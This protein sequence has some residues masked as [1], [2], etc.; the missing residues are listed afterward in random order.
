MFYLRPSVHEAQWLSFIC[1]VNKWFNG[2]EDLLFLLN[3]ICTFLN[4]RSYYIYWFAELILRMCWKMCLFHILSGFSCDILETNYFLQFVSSKKTKTS[5]KKNPQLLLSCR[6][7]T[8]LLSPS[9]EPA[10]NS[11]ALLP[12]WEAAMSSIWTR[13]RVRLQTLNSAKGKQ[14]KLLR[15][16][17][18]SSFP[19]QRWC[20]W[21]RREKRFL[22]WRNWTYSR[23][24]RIPLL[25]K[26][27]GYWN[28]GKRHLPNDS[29]QHRADQ[30]QCSTLGFQL[31]NTCFSRVGWLYRIKFEFILDLF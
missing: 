21:F 9:I 1:K 19:L 5:G 26:W 29:S 2:G 15:P 16:Q 11:G 6:P 23:P 20:D 12:V 24:T 27:S 25:L 28:P 17:R 31:F 3:D 13:Q 7:L 18:Q 30:T 22:D 10:T 8:G 14:Q 4:I